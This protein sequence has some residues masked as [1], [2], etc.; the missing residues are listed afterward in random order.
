MERTNEGRQEAKL[1]GVR[2]GR[3]RT[4]DRDKV[5]S[6][7]RQDIGATA[8]ANQLKIARSTVYKI[9]DDMEKDLSRDESFNH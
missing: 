8:I 1:K 2:F 3:K 7:Y 9:I 5:L 4:V 6:M